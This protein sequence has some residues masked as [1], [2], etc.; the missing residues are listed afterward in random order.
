M[1]TVQ[2]QQSKHDSQKEKNESLHDQIKKFEKKNK[3]VKK[4]INQSMLLHLGNN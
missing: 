2:E 1:G 3:A 4:R